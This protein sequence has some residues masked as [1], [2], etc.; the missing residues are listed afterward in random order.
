MRFDQLTNFHALKFI[1]ATETSGNK[2]KK[3]NVT[4]QE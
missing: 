3:H 2:T 1:L 4:V